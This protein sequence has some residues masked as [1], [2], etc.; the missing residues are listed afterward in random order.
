VKERDSKI[1]PVQLPR[2]ELVLKKRRKSTEERWCSARR[3][4]VAAGEE[5][6]WDSYL[7][8]RF[9]LKGYG[10]NGGSPDVAGGQIFSKSQFFD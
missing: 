10:R 6:P 7:P 4:S 2:R 3:R 8:A 1:E 9:L 5:D